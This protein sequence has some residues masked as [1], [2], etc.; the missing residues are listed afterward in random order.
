M[1]WPLAP[2]IRVFEVADEVENPVIS[3]EGVDD[4][5][6]R[7]AVTVVA[8]EGGSFDEYG[9]CIRRGSGLAGHADGEDFAGSLPAIDEEDSFV[10]AGLP[11]AVGPVGEA[12]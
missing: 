9:A 3:G 1:I 11:A 2:V 10:A 8:V 5:I 4:G 7:P 12:E 6:G